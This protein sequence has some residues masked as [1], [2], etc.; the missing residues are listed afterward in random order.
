MDV[1]RAEQYLMAMRAL[2]WPVRLLRRGHLDRAVLASLGAVPIAIVAILAM[3]D[4]HTLW[5]RLHAASPNQVVFAEDG[6][7][8]SLLKADG[9]DFSGSVGVYVNA[10]GQSWIPYGN[11]HTALGALPALIHPSPESVRVIGLGSGETSSRG[12][13]DGRREARHDLA[14][15]TPTEARGVK[16]SALAWCRTRYNRPCVDN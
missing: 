9:A 3:P 8:L 7:G 11:V 5:A 1:D 6:A 10:L 15:R 2:A 4:A 14:A 16:G 12:R 13:S